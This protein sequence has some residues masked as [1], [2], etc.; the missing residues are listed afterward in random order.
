MKIK[1][2]GKTITYTFD[3]VRESSRVLRKFG[4]NHLADLQDRVAEQRNEAVEAGQKSPCLTPTQHS[5]KE[6]Y[7]GYKCERCEMFVPYGSE[8]WLPVDE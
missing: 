2:R 1:K 5:W 7:Y 3:N 4:A 8:P 6:E